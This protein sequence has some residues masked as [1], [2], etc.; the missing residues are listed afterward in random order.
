M[1]IKIFKPITP[2][3]RNLILLENKNLQKKPTLK[4]KIKGLKKKA[5]RNFEG[6]ITAYH[7][8]G[9][10]KK[11]YRKINFFKTNDS[12]N[13]V[14]SIEY[15]P[16]RTS[17]IAC[18]YNLLT[19]NF[20]YIIA[21]KNLK[22]GDIIKTGKN[23]EPKNGHTLPILKIPIGSLIHNISPKMNKKSQ[24]SRSAGTFSQLI[25]KT[26]SYGRI[27]LSSGE[28]RKLSINCLA[29]IGIVSNEFHLLTNLGKAGRSR[30]LNKRPHVRG[31]AMNPID[32]PHGGGEGKTSGGR[33]S[34]TPWGKPTKNGKTSRS[35]NNLI[36]K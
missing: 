25:E 3:T 5:G 11:K 29:T 1:T 9:G 4:F 27:K 6:K 21:P 23:A 17:N 33:T 24:I 34:V 15:D 31:V 20:D 10:H 18:V 30:W 32:H 36:I 22:I 12:T 26:S 28:Q 19:K 14:L 8:G 7:Q 2:S 16:Y 13:I 35:E